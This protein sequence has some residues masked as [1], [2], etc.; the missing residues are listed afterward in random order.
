[1]VKHNNK[2]TNGHFRKHWECF[3]KTWFDQ[4]AKRRRR[5]NERSGKKK[6][7]ANNLAYVSKFRPIVHCPT[8]MYNMKVK[9]GKGFS[10]SE[11]KNAKISKG[12]ANSIGINIDKR[13]RHKN[14]CEIY[15]SKRLTDY[16]EKIVLLKKTGKKNIVNS[17]KVYPIFSKNF[18]KK[19]N[20]KPDTLT[21][22]LKEFLEENTISLD[23][24]KNN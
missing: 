12:Y 2:I 16:L 21:Q 17:T 3:V 11:M 23:H 13:R 10:V 15:N 24:F 18:R 19:N 1:M 5:R 7:N 20:I 8:H 9:I 22:E 14:L 4:P 6:L